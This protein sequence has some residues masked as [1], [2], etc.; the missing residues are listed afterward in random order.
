MPSLGICLVHRYPQGV[1][2]LSFVKLKFYGTLG[3]DPLS[4]EEMGLSSVMTHL[5]VYD[6]SRRLSHG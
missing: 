4:A 6:G 3:E 2:C 1:D 5:N